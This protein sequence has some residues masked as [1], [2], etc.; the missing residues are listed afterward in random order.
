MKQIERIR[1]ECVLPSNENQAR[2]VMQW[3]NDPVTRHMSFNQEMKKWGDFLQEFQDR[4]FVCPEL[5]SLFILV[6]GVRAGLLSFHPI[7]HPQGKALSCCEISIQIAPEY[8]GKG[9]GSQALIAIHP[10]ILQQGFQ[11]VYAAVKEENLASQKMFLKAGYHPIGH[12]EKILHDSPMSVPI[13]HY[14]IELSTASASSQVFI[15]AEAGSNWRL[16]SPGKDLQMG[17]ALIAAAAEAGADAVKFQTYRAKNLYV[18]NAGQIGYLEGSGFKE[19]VYSLLENFEMPYEMLEELAQECKKWG[20]ELMSTPFSK[21]DFLSI[22][23]FVKRHKI[24]S[25]ELNHVRLLEL[26]AQSGKPLILST[27]AATEAEIEWAVSTYQAY[28]GQDLTLLQCTAAY[29]APSESL[30]LQ[31]IAWMRSRFKV[32]TGLSDHSLHPYYAPIAAASL[33]ATV[34][35]KH[36][37]LDRHLPGPDHAYAILPQELKEMV[38]AVREIEKMR[39]TGFKIENPVETELRTFARRGLQA[40]VPIAKGDLFEEGKNVEILRPGNQRP[41]IHPKFITQL[42]GKKATRPISVGEGI[43]YGDWE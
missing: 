23:P 24:A 28:G 11:T 15:I 42:S 21:Q 14:L 17:K 3:R 34:I 5:P 9:V 4:Y 40:I 27:G 25:Y 31:A 29:P 19:D 20:I 18:K 7:S 6:E 33:G 8:R 26:A 13:I 39:G 37:T 43:Q 10:W 12:S 35:E 16:G 38:K 2:L 36:F 32:P 30:N 41:G 1:F 22:D